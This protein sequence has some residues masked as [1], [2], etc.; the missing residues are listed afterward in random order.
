MSH[1]TDRGQYVAFSLPKARLPPGWVDR[2]SVPCCRARGSPPDGRRPKDAQRRCPAA[3]RPRG[4][5]YEGHT[6][7]MVLGHRSVDVEDTWPRRRRNVRAAK[8]KSKTLRKV[9]DKTLEGIMAL[10]APSRSGGAWALRSRLRIRH[11]RTGTRISGN[12]SS[13]RSVVARNG[14]DGRKLVLPLSTKMGAHAATLATDSVILKPAAK[15]AADA[16]KQRQG[17]SF[18]PGQGPLLTVVSH[19]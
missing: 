6:A 2:P 1:R 17:V 3:V 5:G 8:R 15:T 11:A 4:I 7:L 14:K 13:A 18:Y 9:S 16:I 19:A 12:P 10:S